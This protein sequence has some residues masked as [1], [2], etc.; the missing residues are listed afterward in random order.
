[1]RFQAGVSLYRCTCVPACAKLLVKWGLVA[2]ASGCYW[3]FHC[4]LFPSVHLGSRQ[5]VVD[6]RL[7]VLCHEGCVALPEENEFTGPYQC[8]WALATQIESSFLCLFI[9]RVWCTYIIMTYV[10]V[11]ASVHSYNIPALSTS[12]SSAGKEVYWPSVV[13]FWNHEIH[14]TCGIGIMGLGSWVRR[15][16]S[17]ISLL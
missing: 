7:L 1:M 5:E 15:Q 2:T 3:K 13:T 10:V 8:R 6:I 14:S 11:L 16:S 9:L 4:M 12:I 17:P